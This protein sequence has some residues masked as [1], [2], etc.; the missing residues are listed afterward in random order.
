M[1]INTIHVRDIP[2]D[3][4]PSDKNKYNTNWGQSTYKYAHLFNADKFK[5]TAYDNDKDIGEW[6][7]YA[8]QLRQEIQSN[9]FSMATKNFLKWQ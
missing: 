1:S 2:T 3:L 5:S 4:L 9:G 8:I 7:L 6:I